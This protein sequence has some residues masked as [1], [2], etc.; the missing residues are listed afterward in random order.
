MTVRVNLSISS[1]LLR[2][3]FF[4]FSRWLY[5]PILT[6]GVLLMETLQTSWDHCSF[7]L[8]AVIS[9]A[10]GL[11]SL[12]CNKI[13]IGDNEDDKNEDVIYAISL[14][15]YVILFGI[16]IFYRMSNDANANPPTP[17]SSARN[18]QA[19]MVNRF[20]DALRFFKS[21]YQVSALA[22]FFLI[23]EPLK[24]KPTIFVMRF[25]SSVIYTCWFSCVLSGGGKI[26]VSPMAA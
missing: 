22:F 12:Y 23:D 11:Y 3:F 25:A 10:S 5:L 21:V 18:S 13:I 7:F 8:L 24:S 6:T 19:V 17:N 26:T 14:T 20:L 16:Y 1:H 2:F 4:I 9:S 15:I